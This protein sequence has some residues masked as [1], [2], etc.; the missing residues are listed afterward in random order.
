MVRITPWGIGVALALAVGA[1]PTNPAHAAKPHGYLDTASPAQI[2]GW[3]RDPDHTAPIMVHIYID[4]KLAH[5]M[6]ANGKRPDLPYKD[7]NHGFS[8][9]PPPL[10]P[11]KHQV[12]VYGIGVNTK[13][14]IDGIN[15][16]LTNS[17]S[18]ISAGC[19]GLTHAAAT[20]CKHVSNYYVNRAKDTHY[21]YNSNIR[22]GVN[23]SYGGTILELYGKGHNRNLLTEHGGGAIQLSIW[24]YQQKGP[25]AWFGR[26]SGV[27][28]PT[29]YATQAA[30]NNKHSKCRLWCCSGGAHVTNCGSVK[31]CVDWGAGAPFNPI[32]AQAVNCG[33]DSSTND[34]TSYTSSKGKVS[35]SKKAPYHFTQDNA[36]PGLTWS[37]TTALLAAYVRTDYRVTYN[38][39]Y[40]LS[41]HPQEL[42]AVF[43]GPGMNHTYH[44]YSGQAP[45]ASAA[46]K[47]VSKQ[48]AGPMFRLR[49]RKPYPHSTVSHYLSENWVSA[50][51]AAGKH[52]LTVAV[53]SKQYREIATAGYPGS[54]YGYLTPL[55]GF[56][57][58]PGMDE[59]FSV[60]LFPGRYN[61]TI[62]GKTVRKWI[63]SLAASSK[64]LAHGYP[65]DD[66]DACTTA[67]A[68]DGKGK[69]VGTNKPGC[70]KK[71]AG[72]SKDQGQPKD[73]AKAKDHGGGV[74]DTK[75]TLDLA[76]GQESGPRDKGAS[77]DG[78]GGGDLPQSL[79]GPEQP[80]GDVA[81]GCACRHGSAG[82]SASLALLLLLASLRRRRRVTARP[83]LAP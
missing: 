20:W 81:G 73:Q 36:M 27:C 74:P 40:T 31:S 19:A 68:C 4:G 46:V 18:V 53:F 42:P 15:L 21:L 77:Q 50:C 16:G 10:G 39:P 71:D 43:P 26:G 82:G 63:Y 13:G 2:G 6:L 44:F 41:T 45:Y 83:D 54:G 11:G 60:Y 30:C 3:A 7:Q 33:W 34:V 38:G 59:R 76:A 24:G 78:L 69:C 61:T 67:D 5:D 23:K 51:D 75:I 8:W 65:C 32:Q 64:C 52:C 12:I 72:Q 9:V 25:N 56:N 14:K 28:D 49:N 1:A 66:G 58:R 55:G 57:I 80:T 17:P 37:Q 29:P 47:S 79:D 70:G 62:A 48:S 22:V 35:V